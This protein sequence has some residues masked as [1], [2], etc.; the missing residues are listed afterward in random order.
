M[1]QSRL[2]ARASFRA[3][4][5]CSARLVTESGPRCRAH[6]RKGRTNGEPGKNGAVAE[7]GHRQATHPGIGVVLGQCG[8]NLLIGDAGN[9]QPSHRPVPTPLCKL[10]QA[11]FFL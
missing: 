1:T 4:F 5:L 3:P 8:E 10:G 11:V 2:Q 7:S 6:V 9:G